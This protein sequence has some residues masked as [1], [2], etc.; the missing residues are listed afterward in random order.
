MLYSPQFSC[1][2]ATGLC[3]IPFPDGGVADGGSDA[4]VDGGAPDSGLPGADAG[5]LDAGN[6]AGNDAGPASGSR[7]SGCG[8]TPAAGGPDAFLGLVGLIAFVRRRRQR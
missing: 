7:S 8:C 5:T 4:G 1:D 6:D 2:T 3:S